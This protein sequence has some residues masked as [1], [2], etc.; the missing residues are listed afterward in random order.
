MNFDRALIALLMG[1]V[2]LGPAA[3]AET[4]PPVSAAGGVP[5][6][7][8]PHREM[9]RL[10]GAGAHAV[11]TGYPETLLL[12]RPYYRLLT[13]EEWRDRIHVLDRLPP[14]TRVVVLGHGIRRGA[15]PYHRWY[16]V[17]AGRGRIG[18]VHHLELR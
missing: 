1:I 9:V 17:D 3:P 16:Q 7:S 15:H 2:I 5:E 13:S 11:T 14:G 10:I 8:A 12:D 6:Q 18:W 4:S